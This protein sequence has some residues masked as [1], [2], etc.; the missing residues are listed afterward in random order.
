MLIDYSYDDYCDVGNNVDY[1]DDDDD[2]D[3][4]DQWFPTFFDNS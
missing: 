4:V 3:D 1:D 2:D